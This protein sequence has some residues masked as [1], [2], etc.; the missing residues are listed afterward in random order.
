[1]RTYPFIICLIASILF[2][3]YTLAQKDIY[4]DSLINSMSLE[5][6]IGQLII[7]ASDSKTNTAYIDKISKSIDELNIGGICFFKGEAKT[8]IELNKTYSKRAQIP[9]LFSID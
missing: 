4:I 5:E 9:L 7:I 3:F 2:P 6:K 8:M 1:M